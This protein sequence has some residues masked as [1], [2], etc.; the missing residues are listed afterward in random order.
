MW[1]LTDDIRRNYP[2]AKLL[3]HPGALVR[4]LDYEIHTYIGRPGR[5]EPRCAYLVGLPPLDRVGRAAPVYRYPEAEH[6][7]TL[8]A[9]DP[10]ISDTSPLHISHLPPTSELRPTA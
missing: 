7:R 10:V 4:S 6:G 2:R 9:A 8:H 1:N 3:D 5:A